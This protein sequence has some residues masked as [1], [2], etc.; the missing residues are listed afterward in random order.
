MSPVILG[1]NKLRAP[2][3]HGTEVKINTLESCET[4]ET[5]SVRDEGKYSKSPLKE[6]NISPH[7]AFTN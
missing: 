4:D 3:Q 7:D 5:S 6:N 2:R 1:L